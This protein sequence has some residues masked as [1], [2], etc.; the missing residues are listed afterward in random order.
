MIL[1]FKRTLLLL[2]LALLILMSLLSWTTHL[3]AAPMT[4][5]YHT[6]WLYPLRD[7]PPPPYDCW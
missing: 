7:C 4:P 3:V 1:S 6:H 2:I 5:A